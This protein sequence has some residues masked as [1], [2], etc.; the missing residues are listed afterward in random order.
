MPLD[1]LNN[2]FRGLMTAEQLAPVSQ[3]M[4]LVPCSSGTPHSVLTRNKVSQK[5]N[6]GGPDHETGQ[7]FEKKS[8]DHIRM[9]P[10]SYQTSRAQSEASQ[11]EIS[12]KG[13]Q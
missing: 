13:K 2:D 1:L 10:L 9:P 5:Y 6:M 12:L 7:A 11:S 3:P 8:P 4:L